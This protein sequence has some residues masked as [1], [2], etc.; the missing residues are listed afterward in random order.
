MKKLVTLFIIAVNSVTILNAKPAHNIIAG[1]GF[2]AIGGIFQGMINEEN[3]KARYANDELAA[4]YGEY[5]SYAEDE[6]AHIQTHYL[7]ELNIHK[8]RMG[9]YEGVSYTS[10]AVGSFFLIK[11]ILGAISERRH[12]ILEKVQIVP[13]DGY[14][15]GLLAYNWRF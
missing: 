2:L 6:K 1:M 12:K 8:E 13:I 7:S 5:S 14:S 15:G 3:T 9:I 4:S 10:F 11:G